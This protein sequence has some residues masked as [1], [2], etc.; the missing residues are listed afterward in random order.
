VKI[1][2]FYRTGIV[3]RNGAAGAELTLAPNA[4]GVLYATMALPSAWDDKA[5]D[6]AIRSLLAKLGQDR[7]ANLATAGT[8]RLAEPNGVPVRTAPAQISAPSP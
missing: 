5:C 7:S 2:S 8:Y 4:N 1:G 6:A 3:P